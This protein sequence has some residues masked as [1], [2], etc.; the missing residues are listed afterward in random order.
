[1]QEIAKGFVLEHFQLSVSGLR[2]IKR[3]FR[4][5]HVRS[6]IHSPATPQSRERC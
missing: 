6:S 5:D 1:M 3:V 4:F 2:D